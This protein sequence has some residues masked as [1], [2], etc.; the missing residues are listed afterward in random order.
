MIKVGVNHPQYFPI[1]LSNQT[2]P[3]L[4]VWHEIQGPLTL[5]INFC[6]TD[7]KLLKGVSTP[8]IKSQ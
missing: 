7:G 1:F 4:P 5:G 6:D 2:K 3:W 8:L